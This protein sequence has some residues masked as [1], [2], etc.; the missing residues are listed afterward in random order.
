MFLPVWPCRFAQALRAQVR[1]RRKLKV[2]TRKEGKL[3]CSWV[4]MAMQD[5]VGVK[6]FQCGSSQLCLL[7][8]SVSSQTCSFE[9]FETETL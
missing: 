3:I 6:G 7:L 8:I 2:E 4:T 9:A 1:K 5:V